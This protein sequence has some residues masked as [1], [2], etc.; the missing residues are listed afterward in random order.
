MTDPDITKKRAEQLARNLM[1]Q[2]EKQFRASLP[3]VKL[4]QEEYDLYLDFVGQYGIGNWRGSSM[5]KSL[6][7]GE[8]FSACQSLLKW[9]FQGGRDCKLPQNWGPQG[10]KGVWTRQG[11]RYSRCIT[12]QEG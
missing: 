7:V 2:D 6:L 9:R 1:S 5:R 10:C 4:H 11:E 12:A 8:Y 3:G